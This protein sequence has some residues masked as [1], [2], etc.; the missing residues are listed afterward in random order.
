MLPLFDA[1]PEVDR[2]YLQRRLAELAQQGVYFGGSSWKYEG[3]LG[4]IYTPERYFTRG[5]FSKKRFDEACLQEYAEVFPSVCGDFSYYNFPAPEFWQKLFAEAPQP[6]R[7]S[8]KVPEM[9]TVS[10]FPHHAR[11]GQRAGLENPAF[12]D[13][14]LFEAAF[15]DLLRPYRGRVNAIIIEFS[16]FPR[17]VFAGADEFIAALDRFLSALPDDFRY[18]VEIRNPEFFE[19]PYLECLRRHRVAHVFNA[20]TR[21]PTLA[22][23][24]A[25][26]ESI[27]TDFILARA[28]LRQGRP[29]E[30]AVQ[31]FTPYDRVQDVNQEARDTLR[32]LA[33]AARQRKLLAY[34]YVNNPLEGSAPGTIQAVVEQL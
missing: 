4:S 9:V 7:F 27:T 12:L 30:E 8:F 10:V 11:Y 34:L 31:A 32:A 29:Y 2:Q 25:V 23:Q 21:M 20:W 13:A 19:Q 28:L 24:F 18:A 14:E 6:L 15:L 16:A 17:K 3:W 33:T 22:D 5:R 26:P 1:P